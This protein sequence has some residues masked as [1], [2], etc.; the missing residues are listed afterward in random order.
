VKTQK[1]LTAGESSKDD[2]RIVSVQE[3]KF[4]RAKGFDKFSEEIYNA[5]VE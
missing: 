4:D 1:Q 3:V 5:A 2:V